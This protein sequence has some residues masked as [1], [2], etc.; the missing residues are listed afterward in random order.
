[1]LQSDKQLLNYYAKSKKP[2]TNIP[3]VF[4]FISVKYQEEVNPQRQNA[5]WKSP[6]KLGR[7]NG[8]QLLNPYVHGFLRRR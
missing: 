5:D 3:T 7:R 6:G 8:K 1:M 2:D 4:D